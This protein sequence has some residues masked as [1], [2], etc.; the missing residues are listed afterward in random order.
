MDP[1]KKA[2]RIAELGTTLGGEIG[3]R[4]YDRISQHLD[5]LHYNTRSFKK[6]GE[7]TPDSPGEGAAKD[8]ILSAS[9]RHPTPWAMPIQHGQR[10]HQTV[11]TVMQNAGMKSKARSMHDVLLLEGVLCADRESCTST[12]YR[13]HQHYRAILRN[14]KIGSA[15]LGLVR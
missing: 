4:D 11:N 9:A 10:F 8:E 3:Y 15:G 7:G 13:V 1:L 14:V 2:R 6:G 5:R 12:D